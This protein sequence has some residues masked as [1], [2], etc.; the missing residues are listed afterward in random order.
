MPGCSL[1]HSAEVTGQPTTSTG[2]GTATYAFAIPNNAALVGFHV[3]LQ[4]WAWAPGANAANVIV[5][6][7]LDWQVG[8]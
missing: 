6:N 7:G 8:A 1:L 3:Y 2:S 4:A 5:S